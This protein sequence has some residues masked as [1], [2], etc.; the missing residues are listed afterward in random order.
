MSFRSKPAQTALALI[1][2]MLYGTLMLLWSRSVSITNDY[3]NDSRSNQ[4]T[5]ANSGSNTTIE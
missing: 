4:L 3:L 5:S 1:F 2:V